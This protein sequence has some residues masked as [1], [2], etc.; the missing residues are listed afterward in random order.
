[1]AWAKRADGS[2]I[3]V[4]MLSRKETGLAC[5]CTCAGCGARLEAVNAGQPA[6]HFQKPKAHRM[7]FRHHAGT[8]AGDCLRIASRAA[9]L[10]LLLDEGQ[11]QLPGYQARGRHRGFSGRDYSVVHR[12][13]AVADTIKSHC[14]I[15]THNALI[16]LDS[17]RVVRVQLR[18]EMHVDTTVDAVLTILI[19]D[20]EVAAWDRDKILSLARLEVDW[21]CW[22]KHWDQVQVQTE[23]DNLAARK[24]RSSWMR[25]RKPLTRR[26]RRTA[27]QRPTPTR[28]G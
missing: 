22:D 28:S 4:S 13:A 5:Q 20:P 9:L 15:D 27:R 2:V 23:A 24:P 7:S 6:E 3:H 21:V 10:Q 1:M 11:V 14:W 16:T 26:I 8:Q 19:D 12:G 18:S 25:R 17:G